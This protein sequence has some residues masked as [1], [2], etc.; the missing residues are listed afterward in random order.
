MRKEEWGG[1]SDGEGVVG[2]ELT[3]MICKY[4]RIVLGANSQ[5]VEGFLWRSFKNVKEFRQKMIS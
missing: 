2:E 1:Y 3:G 4:I 5:A